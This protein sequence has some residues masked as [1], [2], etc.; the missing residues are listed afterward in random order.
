M[1]KKGPNTK[2]FIHDLKGPAVLAPIEIKDIVESRTAKGARQDLAKKYGISE[3]RVMTIWNRYYGGSTLKD[4]ASGLKIPL[5]AIDVPTKDITMRRC[6]T[7]RAE[8]AA[9]APKTKDLD[10]PVRASA[11]RKIPARKEVGR[12]L[13]LIPADMDDTDAEIIAGE[14]EAGNNS[15]E[16]IAAMTELINSNKELSESARDSL[17]LA[18]KSLKQRTS[19]RSKYISQSEEDNE[20]NIDDDSTIDYRK[21]ETASESESEAGTRAMGHDKSSRKN[22][23]VRNS[24]DTRDDSGCYNEVYQSNPAVEQRVRNLPHMERYM[25]FD[26]RPG[27]RAT[28]SSNRAKPVYQ[29]KREWSESDEESGDNNENSRYESTISSAKYD[30]GKRG[31]QSNNSYIGNKLGPQPGQIGRISGPGGNRSSETVAVLSFADQVRKRPV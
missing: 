16:L 15:A 30:A 21:Y 9:K 17:K 26:K 3:K 27:I 18:R 8:Y 24:G 19:A 20:S 31:V 29:I 22:G 12:D 28:G 1:T 5:P 11:I 25:E 4:C 14:I 13:E 23:P 2:K 10:R 6:K 7:E